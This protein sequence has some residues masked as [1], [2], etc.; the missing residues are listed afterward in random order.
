MC[1]RL[2]FLNNWTPVNTGK[3]VFLFHEITQRLINVS[4]QALQAEHAHLP[5][6][7]TK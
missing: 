4:K 3:Y 5:E 1:K 2:V 6:Q 7:I